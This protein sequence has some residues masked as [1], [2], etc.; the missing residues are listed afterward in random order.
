MSGHLSATTATRT[1]DVPGGVFWAHTE[2]RDH[3][4]Q[5]AMRGLGVAARLVFFDHTN[6]QAEG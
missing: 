4:N 5:A 3:E 2:P 1:D 6:S